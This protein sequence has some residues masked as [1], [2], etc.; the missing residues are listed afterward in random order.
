MFKFK[1]FVKYYTELNSK[2]SGIYHNQDPITMQYY[3]QNILK[4]KRLWGPYFRFNGKN[5]FIEVINK[6]QLLFTILRQST[7]LKDVIWADHF[8]V[9]KGTLET[10]VNITNIMRKNVLNKHPI[11]LHWSFQDE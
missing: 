6:N 11:F 7:I 8:H 3:D 2:D 4:R 9:G 10:N 5:I 1:T